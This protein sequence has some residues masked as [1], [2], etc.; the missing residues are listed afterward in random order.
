MASFKI[1]TDREI[2]TM[3]YQKLLDLLDDVQCDFDI[4]RNNKERSSLRRTL[5]V[6]KKEIN[7]KKVNPSIPGVIYLPEKKSKNKNKKAQH[8]KEQFNCAIEDFLSGKIKK[9]DYKKL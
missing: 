2:R 6:I 5:K 3:S 8:N 1:P 4:S 7:R 9:S